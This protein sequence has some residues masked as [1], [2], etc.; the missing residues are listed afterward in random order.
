MSVIEGF[1]ALLLIA[2]LCVLI[3]IPSVI[4]LAAVILVLVAV[5]LGVRDRR[6]RP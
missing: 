2:L 1:I 6:T 3:P 5:F 4:V